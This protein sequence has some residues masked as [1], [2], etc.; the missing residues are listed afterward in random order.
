MWSF[1]EGNFAL[2]SALSSTRLPS[3]RKYLISIVL[4]YFLHS[5]FSSAWR[6]GRLDIL[7]CDCRLASF[8]FDFDFLVAFAVAFFGVFAA[9]DL[10]DVDL[11]L[12]EAFVLAL[13]GAFGL[14]GDDTLALVVAGASASTS[15]PVSASLT[16]DSW[17]GRWLQS[18]LWIW[19]A[20]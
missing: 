14:A 17:P 20:T 6:A 15:A 11:A 13:A 7:D 18:F 1:L 5:L 2:K 9:E 3:Q 4:L 19:Q 16:A 12:V 8:D 10:I